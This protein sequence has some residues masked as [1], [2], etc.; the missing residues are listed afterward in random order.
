MEY[1]IGQNVMS[2]HDFFEGVR[3]GKYRLIYSYKNLEKISFSFG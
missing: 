2:G 1:R 3:A